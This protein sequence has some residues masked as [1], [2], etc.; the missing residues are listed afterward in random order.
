[1][2]VA[3]C[4]TWIRSTESKSAEVISRHAFKDQLWIVFEAKPAV[5]GGFAE[6]DTSVG[7][8]LFEPFKS[9]VDQGLAEALALM[10]WSDRDWTQSEPAAV[11]TLDRHGRKSGMA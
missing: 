11:L 8:V 4:A 2:M 6:N 3:D 1:M 5:I 9:L 7:A 10:V